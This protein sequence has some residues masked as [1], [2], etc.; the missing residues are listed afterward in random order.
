MLSSSIALENSLTAEATVG[1][2]ALQPFDGKDLR[3]NPCE[4]NTLFRGLPPY[5]FAGKEYPNGSRYNSN[6]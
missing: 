3:T 4:A 6:G 5:I 2:A 1:K